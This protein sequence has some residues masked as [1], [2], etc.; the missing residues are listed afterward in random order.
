VRLVL[1]LSTLKRPAPHVGRGQ[2]AEPG[3]ELVDG[4]YVLG[5][6]PRHQPAGEGGAGRERDVDEQLPA[7]AAC[8][9]GEAGLGLGGDGAAELRE[10]VG[11]DALA[12]SCSLVSRASF[13]VL[14]GPVA[15]A[16]CC[17]ECVRKPPEVSRTEPSTGLW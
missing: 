3:L 11:I 14:T 2:G 8:A 7:A 13:F 9:A 17:G 10:R 12:S 6:S 4:G 16:G 5:A 15:G 1:Q